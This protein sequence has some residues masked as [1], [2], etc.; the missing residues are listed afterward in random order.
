MLVDHGPNVRPMIDLEPS[1]HPLS[2]EVREG[3]TVERLF[4]L[5]HLA[6]SG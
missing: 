2:V 3:I 4:E 6:T 5:V 1:A